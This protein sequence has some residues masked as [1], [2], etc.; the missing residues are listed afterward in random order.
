[1][2]RVNR[3]SRIIEGKGS[4]VQEAAKRLKRVRIQ[5]FTDRLIKEP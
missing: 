1:M 2:S 5:G 3:F 4:C